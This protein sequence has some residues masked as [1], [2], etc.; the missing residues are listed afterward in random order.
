MLGQLS[1]A[2]VDSLTADPGYPFQVKIEGKGPAIFL[3][4]GL[5]C[6]GNVWDT[7][8]EHLEAHYTCYVFTLAGFAGVKPTDD[9]PFLKSEVKAIE[10][11]TLANK[12]QKPIIIGHSLG[13]FLAWWLAIDQPKM[14]KA[15]VAVDGVP[16]I[17]ALENSKMTVNDNSAN[18]SQM[19]GYFSKM[20]HAQFVSGLQMAFSQQ[21]TS[22]KKISFVLGSA[23]HSNPVA[24]GEAYKE[25]LLTDLRPDVHAVKCPV[26][27]YMS[28]AFFTNPLTLK[29][30][31]NNY[32]AEIRPDKSAK[33]AVA[34]KARHFI[35]LDDPKF[36][37]TT[38]DR[39]LKHLR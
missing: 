7:T 24:V 35:F 19:S 17:G 14:W 20:T 15:I 32:L 23:S 30:A 18:A 2:Q 11:Y 13:G 16:Y 5:A 37:F 9:K 33:L 36:F 28:A 27:Q 39:F 8:V 25:M 22:P 6:G 3:I 10:R 31:K 12:I 29:M 26:L 38:L 21:I 4:P 34:T 1:F